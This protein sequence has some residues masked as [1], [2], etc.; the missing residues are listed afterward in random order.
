MEFFSILSNFFRSCKWWVCFNSAPPSCRDEPRNYPC[1]QSQPF[2]HCLFLTRGK[3]SKL[4][5]SGGWDSRQQAEAQD[6]PAS[7][8][9]TGTSAVQWEHCPKL[10]ADLSEVQGPRESPRATIP[11]EG[12]IKQHS[13]LMMLIWPG[14]TRL[15]NLPPL[16]PGDSTQEHH[17]GTLRCLPERSREASQ[18]HSKAIKDEY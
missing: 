12:T 13:W 10:K 14:L 6:L 9:G 3:A 7:S 1:T 11:T 8:P 4:V 18:L 5:E 15:A 17:W 16:S 2:T